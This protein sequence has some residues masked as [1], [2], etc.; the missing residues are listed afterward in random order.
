MGIV[1]FAIS[2]V[3]ILGLYCGTGH[4]I[5]ELNSDTY[6]LGLCIMLAAANLA[7]STWNVRIEEKSNGKDEQG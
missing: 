4:S 1:N 6:F 2:L 5:Y 7:D 3:I